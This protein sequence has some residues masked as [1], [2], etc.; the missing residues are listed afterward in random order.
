M[1]KNDY[2]KRTKNNVVCVTSNSKKFIMV[3]ILTVVGTS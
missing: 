2:L 3:I 1:S